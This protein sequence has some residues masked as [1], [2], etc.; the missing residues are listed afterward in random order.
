MANSP[1]GKFWL[2]TPWIILACG[3]P[4]LIWWMVEPV[5]VT[6]NYVSPAFLSRPAADRHDAATVYLHETAG[7]KT[8][9]RYIE[10]CVSKPFEAT[11]H[12]SWVGK[13]IVWPAPDLPTTMSREVGCHAF[14][15]AVEVP[16]SS[17]TRTFAFVQRLAI[18]LNPIRTEV[19]EYTPIPLT[20][21]DSK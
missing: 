15:I 18:E 2:L 17:P 1:I 21:L 4:L 5:P 14:N 12:R 11:S 7:N 13:A 9:W 16:S 19:I 8:V 3:L 10:A 20:I 6:V